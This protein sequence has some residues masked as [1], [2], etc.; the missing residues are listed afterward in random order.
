MSLVLPILQSCAAPFPQ[1]PGA[2]DSREAEALLEAS[3]AAHG[4]EAYSK[5]VNISVSYTGQWHALV[6]TLQPDLVDA[7]FRGRSEERMLLRQRLAAQ[8]YAGP[9]G[10]KHVV[11]L[12]APRSGGEV[13]VWVN[14]EETRD[15]N[16]RDAAALV[17]DAYA[18]FLSGPM[19]LTGAW[20]ADRTMTMRLAP[21]EQ[22]TVD[23]KD[24]WCDVLRLRLTP[25]LGL[26]DTDEIALFVDRQERLMRR[27]RFTLNGLESTRG[28]V[29]E[30]DTWQ[31]VTISGVRWPTGFHERLLRPVPLPVHDWHMVGLDTDRGFSALDISGPEF[32]GNASAPAARLA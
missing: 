24:H 29:A 30:V 25:G 5:L 21:P 18:L 14:G 19:L 23:N 4:I 27:V 13:R 20:S 17:A 9:S 8:A 11:R 22:I 6:D 32:A 3:A 15:R 31:H 28:A 12:D 1:L 10:N 16:R 2:S 26:S 7:G